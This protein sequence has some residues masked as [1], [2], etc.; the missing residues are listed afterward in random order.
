MALKIEKYSYSKLDSFNTCPLK[1]KFIYIDQ[2]RKKDESIQA[3]LGK[4]IHSCLEWIYI[5]KLDNKVS[6]FSLDQITN[7]FKG[8]WDERWHSKI[9]FYQFRHPKKLSHFIKQKKNDYFTLGIKTLVNY[10]SKYGP[11]FNQDV[12]RLEEKVEFQIK[13]FNF[14]SIIDRIDNDGSGNIKIIDYKTGKKNLTE[15]KMLKNLQMGI[16]SIAANSTFPEINRDNITLTLFYTMNNKEV[17][18]KAS[19][20]DSKNLKNQIIKNISEIKTCEETSSFDPKE[21]NL[22]NWC[23]YW[24]ECNAKTK[25]NPSLYL[26]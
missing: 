8:Y 13:G 10:Y 9:R 1:Y 20:F 11:N 18:I 3:F 2:I 4:I 7:K 22:C 5:Q 19:E 14:I 6:Y 26:D 16:Y 24:N 23:Y 12:F 17:S 25:D 21:S 15:K